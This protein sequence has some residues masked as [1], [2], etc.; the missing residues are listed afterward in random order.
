[1]LL[2]TQAKIGQ[3]QSCFLK[4]QENFA[5]IQLYTRILAPHILKSLINAQ[6]YNFSAVVKYKMSSFLSHTLGAVCCSSYIFW[7]TLISDLRKGAANGSLIPT[8]MFLSSG[9]SVKTPLER[10]P[11]KFELQNKPS[12]YHSTSLIFWIFPVFSQEVF[13]K[14]DLMIKT[15]PS[16]W[17]WIWHYLVLFFHIF[18]K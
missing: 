2:K 18:R 1:M 9:L 7:S 4:T 8:R 5:K 3:T 17:G 6:P 15:F 16:V 11:G 10:R 12:A 14:K 13:W